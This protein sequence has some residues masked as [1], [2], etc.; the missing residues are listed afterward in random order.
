MLTLHHLNHSRS[1][2]IVWLL[3]ELGVEYKLIKYQRE[4]LMM[5]SP[6]ELWEVNPLGKSPYIEDGPLKLNESAAIIEY[7]INIYGDGRLSYSPGSPNYGKYLQWLHY[8]ES[9]LMCFVIV[10]LVNDVMGGRP[11]YFANQAIDAEFKTSLSYI[12]SVLAEQDYLVDNE[13]SAADIQNWFVLAEIKRNNQ[14]IQ[15]PKIDAYL[16]RL[17][18]R[19]KFKSAMVKGGEFDF[20]AFDELRSLGLVRLVLRSIKAERAKQKKSK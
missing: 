17:E 4:P 16:E 18:A 15:Y 6:S 2:R 20:A 13:F 19:P 11:K 8:A 9:S 5:R 12:E 1:Q 3:E 10:K 14:L 7:I